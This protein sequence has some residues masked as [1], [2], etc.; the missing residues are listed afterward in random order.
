MHRSTWSCS[1]LHARRQAP[2]VMTACRRGDA[3]DTPPTPTPQVDRRHGAATP[4]GWPETALPA[5]AGWMN[6]VRR[7][8]RLCG[9]LRRRLRGG[10]RLVHATH[11]I[12]DGAGRRRTAPAPR[13]CSTTPASFRVADLR[14]RTATRSHSRRRP[15][16]SAEPCRVRPAWSGAGRAVTVMPT[17]SMAAYPVARRWSAWMPTVVIRRRRAR[18]HLV[19]H[20]M[21][22]LV[23]SSKGPNQPGPHR[24][25][26]RLANSTSS[27][28]QLPRRAM[29]LVITDVQPDY[30]D[31]AVSI[32]ARSTRPPGA[33]LPASTGRGVRR[34]G[35]H[36]R[37]TLRCNSTDARS[38][39]NAGVGAMAG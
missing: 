38:S 27:R 9:R 23:P 17:D 19:T 32:S 31:R 20:P 24:S 12:I 16:P 21:P 6:N 8:A 5:P 25:Q 2:G 10:A 36:G 30:L 18:R 35:G 37:A 3:G 26:L 14:E 29:N 34:G 11:P 22:R 39:D 1:R 28:A 33:G 7:R 13:T 4:G 15:F